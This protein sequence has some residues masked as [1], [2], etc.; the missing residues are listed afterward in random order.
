MDLLR[1]SPR[2][3]SRLIVAFLLSAAFAGVFVSSSAGSAAGP[4]PNCNE[5]G[6]IAVDTT[7]DA[8][9]VHVLV[10][11]VTVNPSITLTIKP[12]VSVMGDSFRHLYVRGTLIANG[13]SNSLIT[14]SHSNAVSL[15]PWGGIQ[16]NATSAGSVTWA[17]FLARSGGSMRPRVRPR[18]MTM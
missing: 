11:N 9:C 5:S 8:S 16:F 12:G 13:Q 3:R 15:V 6:N 17:Q 4:L 2:G 10:G 7:W 18:S 14:F 1:L